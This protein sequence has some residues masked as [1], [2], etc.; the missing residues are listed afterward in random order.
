[1]SN[2]VSFKAEKLK[3]ENELLRQKIK[4]VDTRMEMLTKYGWIVE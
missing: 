4:E 3:R 2:I 1:M